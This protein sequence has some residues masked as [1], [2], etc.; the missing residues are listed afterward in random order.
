MQPREWFFMNAWRW[1]CGLPPIE[2]TL[3]HMPDLDVLKNLQWDEAFEVSCRNLMEFWDEQFIRYCKRRMIQGA[4]R[5][6]TLE[7]NKNKDASVA[8]N[9]IKY[10]LERFWATKDL[11]LLC[12]AANFAFIAFYNFRHQG[13]EAM[14]ALIPRIHATK[15]RSVAATSFK[16]IELFTEHFNNTHNLTTLCLI[17]NFCMVLFSKFKEVPGCTFAETK[18]KEIIWS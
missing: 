9:N 12:D 10:R 13:Y 3:N 15:T 14:P 6:G 7:K 2:Y 1:K 8:L 11:T 17:F 5:Y 4:F 18:T 16:V